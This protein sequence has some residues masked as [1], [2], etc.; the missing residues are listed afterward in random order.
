MLSMHLEDWLTEAGAVVV[1]KRQVDAASLSPSEQII[2]EIWLLDTETRNGGLS[3]YFGN[4]GP[5]QWQR[6][7][8]AA[9]F[10]NL[11]SFRL[12][13]A[14]VGAFIDSSEDAYQAFVQQGADAENLWYKYQL[15]VVT[16]LYALCNHAL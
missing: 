5:A 9:N 4:R 1:A 3:Q 6:C 8:A 16:E 7:V 11:S 13:A 15:P 12:F 14:E 2:Y 10:A